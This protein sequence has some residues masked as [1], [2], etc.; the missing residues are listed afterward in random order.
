M[1]NKNSGPTE[2]TAKARIY[3]HPRIIKAFLNGAA[4]WVCVDSGGVLWWEESGIQT[5][6]PPGETC[7][8]LYDSHLLLKDVDDE[9]LLERALKSLEE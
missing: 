4:I 7:T 6:I 1:G 9:A 3:S 8:P 5:A 2:N